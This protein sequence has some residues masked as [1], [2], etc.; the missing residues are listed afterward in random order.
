MAAIAEQGL[1]DAVAVGAEPGGGTH[2]GSCRPELQA[3]LDK[4]RAAGSMAA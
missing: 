4:A 3:L 1:A 2:C